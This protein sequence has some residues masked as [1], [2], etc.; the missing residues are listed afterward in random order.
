MNSIPSAMNGFENESQYWIR[1]FEFSKMF[2]PLLDYKHC[3]EVRFE[4]F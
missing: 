2:F 4:L 1:E 3:C